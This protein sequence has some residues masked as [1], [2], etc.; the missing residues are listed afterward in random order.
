[1]EPLYYNRKGLRIQ[2]EDQLA[3][4]DGCQWKQLLVNRLALCI[5][6]F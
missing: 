1:M 4:D 2:L 6:A 5:E 3:T